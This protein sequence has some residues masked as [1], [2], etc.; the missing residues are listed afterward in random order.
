M[1]KQAKPRIFAIRRKAT[2][3]IIAYVR[4]HLKREATRIALGEI[5]TEEC[6]TDDLIAIGRDGTTVIGMEPAIDPNQQD[7]PL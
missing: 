6:G 1:R 4:H 5:E 7:L 3:E 2:G